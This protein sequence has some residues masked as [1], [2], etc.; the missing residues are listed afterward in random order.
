MWSMLVTGE[1]VG[2]RP[3]P[4]TPTRNYHSRAIIALYLEGIGWCANSSK[5]PYAS[6]RYKIA[7]FP[8]LLPPLY[9]REA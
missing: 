2:T 6:L 8:G 5:I 4:S 9:R 1:G 7:S 3:S